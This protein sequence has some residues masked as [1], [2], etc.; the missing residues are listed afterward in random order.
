ML[1]K[2]LDIISIIK[3]TLIILRHLPTLTLRSLSKTFNGKKV[4]TVEE[5]EKIRTYIASIGM[6]LFA[7]GILISIVRNHYNHPMIQP[8]KRR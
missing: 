5:L 2:I 3:S 7:L 4:R 6:G 1:K 8:S